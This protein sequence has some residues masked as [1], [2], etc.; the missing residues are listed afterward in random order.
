MLQGL[1]KM[2]GRHAK[3]K[4]KVQ[5]CCNYH[6]QTPAIP[7]NL[8]GSIFQT[9]WMR[10]VPSPQH[11][12]TLQ[13]AENIAHTTQTIFCVFVFLPWWFCQLFF[14]L[15]LQSW[16]WGLLDFMALLVFTATKTTSI[17]KSQTLPISKQL[18]KH[19]TISS[20]WC[21]SSATRTHN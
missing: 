15:A 17:R 3:W 11:R 2:E 8:K 7:C 1:S 9:W 10:E 19:R 13:N 18:N 5:T 12:L 21:V 20:C 14:F 6:L 4:V 16:N